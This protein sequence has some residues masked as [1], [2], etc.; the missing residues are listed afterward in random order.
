MTWHLEHVPATVP[1]SSVASQHAVVLLA[2]PA[3][4]GA[5]A[6]AQAGAE[7]ALAPAELFQSGREQSWRSLCI[8]IGS[9]RHWHSV[10]L[11]TN[12]VPQCLAAGD[13]NS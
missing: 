7:C 10:N 2:A 5:A 9:S 6:A 11:Q 3:L 4:L 8:Q 13:P 12:P 1:A